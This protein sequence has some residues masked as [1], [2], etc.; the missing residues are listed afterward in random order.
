MATN[1][2]ADE[3]DTWEASIERALDELRAA[4]DE[5][6]TRLDKDGGIEGMRHELQKIG[7]RV[8]QLYRER[9]PK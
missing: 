6:Q 3:D 8:A 4:L 2:A 7:G 5:L 9:K 1:S